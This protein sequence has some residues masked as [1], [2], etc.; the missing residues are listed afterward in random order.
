MRKPGTHI[1]LLLTLLL[2]VL[3]LA[4]SACSHKDV[5]CPVGI[6]RAINVRFEWDEYPE[7]SPKGMTLMFYPISQG[8]KIWRFDIAGRDGGEVT[9]P[10]GTYAMLAFNNDLPG[11]R[12]DDLGSFD[13]A[14]AHLKTSSGVTR[15]CGNLYAATVKH[16]EITPCGVSYTLPSG[17]VK[18]CGKGLVRCYPRPLCSRYTVRV[19]EVR[20]IELLCASQSLI[21]RMASCVNLSKG[22][23]EPLAC[24]LGIEMAAADE[25]PALT[26]SATCFGPVPGT[27]KHML[28][29]DI[30]RTDGQRLSKEF[31]VTDQIRTAPNPR[32][33]VI[34]IQEIEIPPD[35]IPPDPGGDGSDVGIVVGIDGW[36]VVNIDLT[37]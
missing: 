37:T 17:K 8:A 19:L 16:L 28:R 34:T 31:D 13:G 18:E 9:L 2:T 29:L 24:S 4:G 23:P 15:G 14:L 5:V 10:V 36:N 21:D 7:A 32:D 1:T 22:R 27:G 25:I 6:E 12:A 33:V 26:G 35:S 11:V 3:S 30:I 20:N